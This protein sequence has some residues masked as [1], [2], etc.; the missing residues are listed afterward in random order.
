MNL[1]PGLLLFFAPLVQDAPPAAEGPVTVRPVPVE[2]LEW[3]TARHAA[4]LERVK[5]ARPRAIFLGDSITHGWE[6]AGAEEWKRR[7]APLDALNLGFSGDCTQHLLWRLRNGE[8]EHIAP[9]LAVVMIGTNNATAGDSSV[10]I[11]AGVEAVLSELGRRLPDTKVLL[12]AIFPRG[13]DRSNRL[14]QANRRTNAMLRE[15]ADGERVHWLDLSDVFLEEDGTLSREVMPDLVHPSAEGYRRWA[16]AMAPELALLLD[17]SPADPGRGDPG[18]DD[19]REDEGGADEGHGRAA[20]EGRERDARELHSGS[21][22]RAALFS[23]E[24]FP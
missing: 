2:G 17:R 6:Q 16:E 12:L 24:P 1:C 5:T 9:E 4:I 7:Y 15:L 10:D 23:S 11:A 13:E 20:G 18:R 14:R 3:W 8:V 22:P 19:R 21:L